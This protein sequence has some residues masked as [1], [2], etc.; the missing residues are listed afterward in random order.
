MLNEF[1]E[2]LRET[3][4]FIG[5]AFKA[6]CFWRRQLPIVSPEDLA[7]FAESRAKYASQSVL[8]DYVKARMGTRHVMMLENPEFARSVN[9]AK[10]E[11]YLAC[12]ADLSVYVTSVVA[13]EN[14]ELEPVEFSRFVF[15]SALSAEPVPAER[16]QGFDDARQA[17]DVRTQAINVS[18]E[19][20]EI[21]KSSLDAMVH[22]A[23]IADELKK[24]DHLIIRNA[25]RFKW[26]SI[27]EQLDKR[28]DAA[29]VAESWSVTAHE[30]NVARTP[31][32]R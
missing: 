12:L 1:K 30:L 13:R 24:D 7:E 31:L 25:L 17:F 8:Y 9:I 20:D 21:F 32:T 26:K 18:A 28:L 5:L 3:S 2:T 22:W 19:L 27:R 16:P 6:M 11:V 15:E 23:P 14:S 4:N 10:W 29:A